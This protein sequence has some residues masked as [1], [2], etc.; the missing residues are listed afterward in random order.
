[1]A[2]YESLYHYSYKTNLKV[3]IIIQFLI[4]FMIN[5]FILA[6]LVPSMALFIALTVILYH[7]TKSHNVDLSLFMF[8]LLIA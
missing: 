1:M 3:Y 4:I 8:I 7:P 6:V 2:L 5:L